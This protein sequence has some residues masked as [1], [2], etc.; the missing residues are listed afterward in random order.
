MIRNLKQLKPGTVGFQGERERDLGLEGTEF[1]NFES[2]A[3]FGNILKSKLHFLK[4]SKKKPL[5]YFDRSKSYPMGS[6]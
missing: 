6:T 5:I 3:G 4:N 2:D 1:G